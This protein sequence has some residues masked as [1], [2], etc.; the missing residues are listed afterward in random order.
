MNP[1][2]AIP[3]AIVEKH[4]TSEKNT[5]PP[6]PSNLGHLKKRYIPLNNTPLEFCILSLTH[7]SLFLAIQNNS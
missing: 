4:T 1:P 7:A 2:N 5:S 3:L 6:L